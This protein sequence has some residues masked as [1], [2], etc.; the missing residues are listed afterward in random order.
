MEKSEG[1]N[2]NVGEKRRQ[3]DTEACTG[4]TAEK[5]NCSPRSSTGTFGYSIIMNL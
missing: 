2:R 5:I 1:G 3:M 4:S